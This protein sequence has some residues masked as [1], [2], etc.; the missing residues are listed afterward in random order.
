LTGACSTTSSFLPQLCR[1]GAGRDARQRRQG[2]VAHVV[3]QLGLDGE[4]SQLAKRF[5]NQIAS[6]C[7]NHAG[8]RFGNCVSWMLDPGT[9]M[10]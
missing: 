7:Y 6:D 2:I 10:F 3:T 9:H 1:P 5:M 4:T 8:Y